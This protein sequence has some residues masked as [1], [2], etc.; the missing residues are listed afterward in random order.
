MSARLGVGLAVLTVVVGS[1][2]WAQ[3]SCP[4][5]NEL[6]PLPTGSC[7]FSDDVVIATPCLIDVRPRDFVISRQVKVEGGGMFSV[8]GASVS[9]SVFGGRI[10]ASGEDGAHVSLIATDSVSIGAPD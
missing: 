8:F 2:A 1:G 5:V 4:D 7:Y 9:V 6:C 3:G 10:D